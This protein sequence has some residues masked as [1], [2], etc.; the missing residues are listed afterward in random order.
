MPH[1]IY[2]VAVSLDGYIA[3]GEEIPVKLRRAS[4]DDASELSALL[5][6][7]GWFE[8][9]NKL[10]D[11]EARQHVK[12]Q[13]ERCL[14]DDSHSV[15]VA[16]ADDGNIVGYV[17]AHWI[18]YLFMRG[19]EG[20]VSELFIRGDARAQ[21]IGRRLLDLV[22]TEAKRRG[23]ARL[24]LINLRSRESYQR[25]FYIKAGWQERADAANFVRGLDGPSIS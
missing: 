22:Q 10:L 21:G 17:S 20:Y 15:Y 16:E 14:S 6:S 12:A 11:D 18:P 4:I 8:F 23:C 9:T 2:Y 1:I 7:I 19:P 25:Q 13:L 3:T 24:S 5:K